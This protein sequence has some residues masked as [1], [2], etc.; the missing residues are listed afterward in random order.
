MKTIELLTYWIERL[1]A[2]RGFA[3]VQL[4]DFL[5]S[6]LKRRQ[7]AAKRAG[8][9]AKSDDPKKVRNREYQREYQRKRR[10]AEAE[11]FAKKL[12]S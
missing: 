7:N 2:S 1:T 8:C 10:K 5:G 6:E 9:P 4:M 3:E 11:A 12:R